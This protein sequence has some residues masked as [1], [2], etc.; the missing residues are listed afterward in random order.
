MN[1]KSELCC[2][3]KNI[4]SYSIQYQKFKK[5]NTKVLDL[6]RSY[7]HLC[8]MHLIDNQLQYHIYIDFIPCCPVSA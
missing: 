4:L 8:Q 3:Q 1:G 5:S 7:G 2:D 6:S